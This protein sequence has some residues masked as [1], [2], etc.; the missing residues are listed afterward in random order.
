MKKMLALGLVILFIVSTGTG[1]S[2][3]KGQAV[4]YKPPEPPGAYAHPEYLINVD[5]LKTSLNDPFLLIIDLRPRG[6]YIQ[7]HIPGA[8][9]FNSRYITDYNRPGRIAPPSQ[10]KLAAREF[11]ISNRNKVVVYGASYEQTRLWFALYMYG[12]ES[13]QMLDG[14]IDKWKAKG[15]PVAAGRERRNPAKYTPAIEKV[16][17]VMAGTEEIMT[18]MGNTDKNVIVDARSAAEYKAGHIPGSINVEWETMINE[19]KT[20]KSANELK[21]IFSEKGI[22]PDNKVIV[23]SNQC[24]R[25]SYLYFVLKQLLGHENVKNYDGFLLYWKKGHRPLQTNI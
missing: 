16:P 6:L 19:D 22:T 9:S 3:K 23:Y 13:V 17:E 5:Q 2:A 18:A 20:F 8:I 10:F 11:G 25:S 1:C 21:K 7:E 4:N 15:Y 14:G 12:H 24:Y